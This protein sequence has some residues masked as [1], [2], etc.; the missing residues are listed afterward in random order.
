MTKVAMAGDE[1][2]GSIIGVF[3]SKDAAEDWVTKMLEVI[4]ENP[5]R[6]IDDVQIDEIGGRF[7]AGVIYKALQ[8]E[9]NF[10]TKV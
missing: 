6:V 7:R 1:L 8:T 3:P 4:C 9:M 2:N 10:E 5:E